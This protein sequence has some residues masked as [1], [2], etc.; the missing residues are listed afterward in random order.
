M[1]ETRAMDFVHDSWRRGGRYAS[2][3]V[4]VFARFSPVIVRSFS[5]KAVDVV[6]VL[7]KVCAE[8]GYPRTIGID[9]SSECFER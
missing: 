1:G 8:A 7:E 4:G 9:Q 2:C 6:T 3:L 5:F